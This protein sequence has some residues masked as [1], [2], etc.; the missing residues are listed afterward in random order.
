MLSEPKRFSQFINGWSDCIFSMCASMSHTNRWLWACNTP[1]SL[2][3]LNN[4]QMFDLVFWLDSFFSKIA[5][6][7]VLLHG[8]FWFLSLS[9]YLYLIWIS[10]FLYQFLVYLIDGLYVLSNQSF[11]ICRQNLHNFLY[12]W[13]LSRQNSELQTSRNPRK[14]LKFILS[15][16]L[17][18]ISMQGRIQSFVK[19][20]AAKLSPLISFIQRWKC[21]FIWSVLFLSILVDTLKI[22]AQIVDIPN[23]YLLTCVIFDD[24]RI[25]S[26]M[27]SNA[28][29]MFARWVER[30]ASCFT[31]ACL[32]WKVIF[33]QK[34][35]CFFKLDRTRKLLQIV[36]FAIS[37]LIWRI[38]KW[39]LKTLY[40]IIVSFK[41][42]ERFIGHFNCILINQINEFCFFE[43][44]IWRFIWADLVQAWPISWGVWI[45]TVLFA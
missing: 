19:Q 41:G 6:K 37:L 15:I 1:T 36:V 39:I 35:P 9:F 18:R 10:H 27:T 28:V 40:A 13:V 26:L 32:C 24:H 20:F 16:T 30:I 34:S 33:M 44:R 21:S 25:N 5:L 2:V 23:T 43:I 42:L 12:L 7:P 8:W 29:N 38:Y 11:L 4:L 45:K 14:S 17:K 3:V 22:N 31:I